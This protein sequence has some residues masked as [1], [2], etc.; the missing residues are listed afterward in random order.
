MVINE[1]KYNSHLYSRNLAD[2]LCLFVYHYLIS[3]SLLSSAVYQVRLI[4]CL[5]SFTI[6]RY[7]CSSGRDIFWVLHNQQINQFIDVCIPKFSSDSFNDDFAVVLKI[8]ENTD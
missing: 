8:S 3:F 6:N 4:A 5:K 7:E 1:N 2:K